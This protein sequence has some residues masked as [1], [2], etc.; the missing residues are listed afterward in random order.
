MKRKKPSWKEYV[1]EEI[2]RARHDL[3]MEALKGP[4]KHNITVPTIKG[5][6]GRLSGIEI[7]EPKPK[8]KRRTKTS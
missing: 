5:E 7:V 6:I 4:F 1:R 8:T 3:L 2:D